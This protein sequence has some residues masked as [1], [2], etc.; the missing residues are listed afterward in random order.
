MFDSNKKIYWLFNKV[1]DGWYEGIH[2]GKRGVFPSNYVEKL[3]DSTAHNNSNNLSNES[4][5]NSSSIENVDEGWLSIHF[6]FI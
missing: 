4:L 5:N 2:N 1:E 3:S 6:V